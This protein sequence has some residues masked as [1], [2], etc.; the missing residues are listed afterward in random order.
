MRE[1]L[2]GPRGELGD[3]RR[4]AQPRPGE[5]AE[6]AAHLDHLVAEPAHDSAEVSVVGALGRGEQ[7]G[8]ATTRTTTAIGTLTAAISAVAWPRMSARPE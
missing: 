4:S 7:P 1:C 2:D 6:A 3:D 8:P 5:H